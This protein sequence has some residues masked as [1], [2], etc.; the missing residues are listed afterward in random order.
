M[1]VQ[2]TNRTGKTYYLREGKTKT[3]KPRYFFSLQQDG[4]GEVV[5]HIPE[6]YEIY[7]HPANAQV[8]LRKKRPKHITD[9][10]KHL[11]EKH[12]KQLKR[13]RRYR[14][15]CKDEYITVYE[16]DADIGELKDMLGDFLKHTALRSVINAD[17]AT[18]TLVGAA[19]QHYTAM[20]R[21]H[22]VDKK[23]RE[24]VA[25]RFCF[26]GA[27]NDWIFLGGPDDLKKLVGKYIRLLGTEE[28]FNTPYF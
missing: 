6:G 24:F 23:R 2:Y 14:V 19:E 21:F 5:E 8:F 16:S 22:L 13:S 18:N 28:F 25:E 7:E 4:K 26:Q 1:T 17:E 11:V 3:G 20:L 9:I 12:T 27:I 10:E 15:D